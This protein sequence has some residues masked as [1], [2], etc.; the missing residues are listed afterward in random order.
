[1]KRRQNSAL[2][3][4]ILHMEQNSYRTSVF[5]CI[6]IFIQVEIFYEV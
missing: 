1:M 6:I 3:N 5:F 2:L 4:S